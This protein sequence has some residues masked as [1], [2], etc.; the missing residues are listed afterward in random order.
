MYPVGS[1]DITMHAPL[2]W[3]QCIGPDGTGWDA[4]IQGVIDLRA[5]ENPP[6]DMYYV[7]AFEPA[8][9][10]NG[11]CSQ[12]CILGI[13]LVEPAPNVVDRAAF[14]VGYGGQPPADT[15]NQELAHSMGRLHAP[16]G[17]P[18]QVDPSFPYK[19]GGIGVWGY[20]ILTQTSVDPQSKVHDFMSYCTPVWVSDYTYQALFTR[21]S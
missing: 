7:A 14:I 6:K 21:L 1:V 10:L 18:Q 5:S 11:Y 20:D 13:G 12:G 17:R 2:P 3:N 4:V 8:P 16:C 9:T 15:L 19:S